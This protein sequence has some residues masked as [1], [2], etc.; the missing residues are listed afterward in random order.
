MSSLT[1][2]CQLLKAKVRVWVL[3]QLF[4]P[5]RALTLQKAKVR[6]EE[7]VTCVSSMLHAGH[8]SITVHYS[9]QCESFYYGN[10]PKDLDLYLAERQIL[11]GLVVP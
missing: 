8:A 3:K 4:T 11:E 5:V 1:R 6:P 10:I 7:K 2:F 9:S